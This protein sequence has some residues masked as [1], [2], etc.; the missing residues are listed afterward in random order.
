M[1][2]VSGPPEIRRGLVTVSIML[3]TVMQ[4]LDTTIANVALPHIQGSLSAAADQITWVLTS[5]IVAAAIATP[6]TGWLVGRYGLKWVFL[7]SVAGFTMASALC[8]MAGDLTEIVF[9]RLLQGVCGAAL[10]PL[11][12]SVLLDINPPEKVGSAMAIW[13]AG[14]MVGP[15]LGP[16]LGG[17]LTDHFDWRWVFY[18]N[19]PVGILA[20][21]GIATFIPDRRNDSHPRFDFFGFA[22]LSLGVGA[23]QM[24][25]DRGELKGWFGAPE[26]WAEALLCL[27]GFYLFI[28]HTTLSETT[29][30]LN[31][32][33]LKDRNFVAGTVFIFFVGVILYATLA[34]LPPMLQEL[35]NYPVT[36]TGLVT[37]PRGIGT[38][39]AM[40][41]TG[42][43]IGRVDV[44][45]LIFIGLALTSFALWQMTQFDLQMGMQPVILSGLFQGLGLGFV[46]TPLS[47]VTFATLTRQLRTEGTAIFSLM[48]NIGSSIGISIV[49]A[50]L[51]ENTQIIHSTL[52]EH[53]RPDNPLIGALGV[54]LQA[55]TAVQLTAINARLTQQAV[56]IAYIDDYKLMMVTA[57]A[58]MPLLL[59]LRPAKSAAPAAM[60]LE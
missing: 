21:L 24:M 32:V 23:L 29:T 1:T 39:A 52:V 16:A 5:Y 44:R 20:F 26:I 4:A 19:L 35:F 43:L 12:Q 46:F 41:V 55:A 54:H 6:V 42:K 56:M 7:A 40:I 59:L 31:R 60:P 48:R 38:M 30:F 50:L 10:V 2:A 33:L 53:I 13:G 9:F 8:G 22:T 28:V 45:L 11:S 3:A 51:S 57:I 58:M 36:L 47:T 15:I 49:T 18:I 27:L 34:L 14:I 25:L 17:W 37:A